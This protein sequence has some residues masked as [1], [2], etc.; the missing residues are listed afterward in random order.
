MSLR[1]NAKEAPG[2]SVRTEPA[3]VVIALDGRAQQRQPNWLAGTAL[4]G[5]EYLVFY[6][7]YLYFGIGCALTSLLSA[8][9]HPLLPR[10]LGERLGRRLTA[11]H[12][13]AFLAL[14]QASGL[15]KLELRALDAL[16]G[17]H[18]GRGAPSV[19]RL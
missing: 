9:L 5:N 7:G 10:V 15:V 1:A 12:F 17:Q 16:R 13:R 3:K 18:C 4:P 8:A 19:H 11:L 2:A 14:L 6:L